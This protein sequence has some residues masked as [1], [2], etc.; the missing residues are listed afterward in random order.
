MIDERLWTL[1]LPN[2]LFDD[3][4]AGVTDHGTKRLSQKVLD[5]VREKVLAISEWSSFHGFELVF[6]GDDAG[7]EWIVAR[8][9]RT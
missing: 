2:A 8:L 3:L 7:Y 4:R 9:D 5:A 6:I 1:R